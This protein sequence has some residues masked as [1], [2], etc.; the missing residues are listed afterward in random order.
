MS[1][2]VKWFSIAIVHIENSKKMA[3]T[4]PKSRE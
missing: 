3:N 1:I 2:I 4:L